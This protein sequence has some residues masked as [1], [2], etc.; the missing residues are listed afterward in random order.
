M[1][2]YVFAMYFAFALLMGT[3]FGDVVPVRDEERAFMI[4]SHLCA[5]FI[6]AYLVGGVVSAISSLNARNQGFYRSM[7]ILN[8]FLREKRL[9]AKNPK[10]CERL[11]SYYLFRHG[12]SHSLV[13]SLDLEGLTLA[14]TWCMRTAIG[15]VP[16]HRV[17]VVRKRSVIGC[18]RGTSCGCYCCP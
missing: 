12:R 7:D 1:K 14:R 10:L 6:N 3:S 13:R 17:N 2:K 8:R 4:F 11:R 15:G 9:T 5:G 16:S 18:V